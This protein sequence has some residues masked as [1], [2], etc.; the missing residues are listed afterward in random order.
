MLDF[1]TTDTDQQNE[2]DDYWK[3]IVADDDADVLSVTRLALKNLVYQDKKVQ[4]L[5]AQSGEATIKLMRENPDTAVLLLDM[6]METE[7]SGSDVISFIRD[8]L[9]NNKVQIILRTGQPGQFPEEEVIIN[10]SI[11]DYKDKTELTKPKLV[12]AVVAALRAY[13]TINTLEALNR[14]LDEKVQERT[15]QINDQKN[16]LERLV[17]LKNK[18]FT[19]ISHDLRGPLS[20]FN[21]V[22]N[23]IEYYLKKEYY[24]ELSEVAREIKKSSSNLSHLLDN[25]LQWALKDQQQF[26]YH[27]IKLDVN[28]CIEEITDLFYQQ[29]RLKH[30]DL[31]FE[32][33]EAAI[34][35]VDEPSFK[36]IIRNLVSNALKFTPMHGKVELRVS[37]QPSSL[38]IEIIDDGVGMGKDKVNDLWA[39][40]TGKSTWGTAGEKGIGLGLR[41]VY[42]F[43]LLNNAS[44]KVE[45]KES[46]GTHFILNFP[47]EG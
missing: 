20:V 8:T 25:L 32:P 4:L 38:Q 21:S 2:S 12:T 11:N 22:S 13:K 27:P 45:S 28:K 30:I 14:T 44:I 9:E 33:K 18:F 47:V 36:T 19:I 40:S 15:A 23:I 17:A 43:A 31:K 5:N 29:A 6:I 10:Q 24:D 35:W 37:K 34:I 42:E 41:L 39:I 16:E 26:P 7:E 46:H 3:I 1:L